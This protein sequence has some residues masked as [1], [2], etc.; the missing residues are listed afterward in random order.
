MKQ[1][2]LILI[3]LLIS[4][5]V[6]YRKQK[7]VYTDFDRRIELN[8]IKQ[9]IPIDDHSIFFG[10]ST[11]D[12]RFWDNV[13]PE[14][15]GMPDSL[16]NIKYYYSWFNNIQALYQ[17]YKAGV[18]HKNDFD[19]Y[20]NAWGADTADCIPEYV[21]TYAIIATGQSKT[22]RKYFL[23]DSNNDYDLS[24]EVLFETSKRN[25]L[26]KKNKEHQPYKILYEKV[27]NKEI[28]KDSTWVAFDEFSGRMWIKF[29]EKTSASFQFDSVNY[30]IEVRP[31]GFC[32]YTG[33]TTFTL[34]QSISRQSNTYDVGEYVKLGNHYYKF[35]CSTDGSKIFLT[36]DDEALTNGSTQIGMPPLAFKAKSCSG[37]S[38]NFPS[39]YKGKYVLLD[40]WATNCGPC[41]QEMKDYYIDIYKRYGGNEFEIVGV[42][43]NLPHELEIFLKENNI[44]WT[45]V[46]DGEEKL[47]QKEYNIT[48]YP[49]LYFID[50]DG[51]IVA[52][53]NDL[54]L[55]K[56][57]STLEEN[58]KLN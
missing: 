10:M 41:I 47:I 20:Y 8:A 45:I 51:K 32:L 5:S 28:Q 7:R 34:T 39:D 37:D 21:K 55:G 49:T 11:K 2:N 56:F 25:S 52:K 23:F 33:G 13:F 12:G 31:S 22:G 17:S 35:N 40:F 9:S 24:D 1:Y 30:N 50:P 43:N 14:V 27:V 42:A 46:A 58:I 57:V 53:E 15:K 29:C 4:F 6:G 48:H 38:I 3:S 26:N 44:K 54:R 18:V 19:Y 16:A 36:K